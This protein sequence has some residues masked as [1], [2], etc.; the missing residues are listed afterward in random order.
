MT[1]E[2]TSNQQRNQIDMPERSKRQTDTRKGR[3]IN[4]QADRKEK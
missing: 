1:Q 2:E 3:Q 4:I